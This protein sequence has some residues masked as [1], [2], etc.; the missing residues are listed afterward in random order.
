MAMR[1]ISWVCV[2]K[3]S[4][5][6]ELKR[7]FLGVFVLGG[8]ILFNTAIL[9]LLTAI[10]SNEYEEIEKGKHLMFLEGRSKYCLKYII[11]MHRGC[12]QDMLSTLLSQTQ[13]VA[14]LVYL[15]PQAAEEVKL[16]LGCF[17]LFLIVYQP[18]DNIDFF[19]TEVGLHRFTNALDA[20]LEPVNPFPKFAVGILVHYWLLFFSIL[21]AFRMF[22]FDPLFG[23][24]LLSC[25]QIREQ[26]AHIQADWFKP[27][28]EWG[29][30]SSEPDRFLWICHR[31]D[32]DTNYVVGR[33]MELE[34]LKHEMNEH[35]RVLDHQHS[36]FKT[37]HQS[38][39][40]EFKERLRRLEEK[41]DQVLAGTT[42][43][44]VSRSP[45]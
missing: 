18:Q 6:I 32:F 41:L 11:T 7:V 2:H 10:Y 34:S 21:L 33:D 16:Y 24:L 39:H 35:F 37:N 45:S 31:S 38:Q 43:P 9:N 44:P 36:H 20:F 25:L 8:T 19:S 40:N 14:T 17:R 5:N 3:A 42:I 15:F 29:Q 30:A 13:I 12:L 1:W 22:P 4:Q 27:D 28:I 23:A 26:F